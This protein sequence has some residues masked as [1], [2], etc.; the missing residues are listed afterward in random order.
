MKLVDDAGKA[1]TWISMWCMGISTAFLSA[2][3]LLPE[4]LKPYLLGSIPP[5]HVAIGVAGMLVIGMLGRVVKQ[6]D[7]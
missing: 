6:G 5:K 4:D 1:W 2:W 3:A 7:K